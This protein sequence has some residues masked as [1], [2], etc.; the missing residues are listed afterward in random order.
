MATSSP[1]EEEKMAKREMGSAAV[2]GSTDPGA[3]PDFI[4]FRDRLTRLVESLVAHRPVPPGQEDLRGGR[5]RV[6]VVP[7]VG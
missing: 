1:L 2:G 6:S 4:S 3:R 7:S 5:E